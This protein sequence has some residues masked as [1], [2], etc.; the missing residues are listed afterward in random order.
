M[1]VRGRGGGCG[2]LFVSGWAW[3]RGEGEGRGRSRAGG[4]GARTCR[5]PCVRVFA[6]ARACFRAQATRR[7]YYGQLFP[8][9]PGGANTG[10]VRVRAGAGG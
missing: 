4:G 10:K 8:L 7:S 2:R 1:R 3:A 6:C 5:W 9:N